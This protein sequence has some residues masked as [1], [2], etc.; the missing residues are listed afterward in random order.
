MMYNDTLD[1]IL[2]ILQ[3]LLWGC[4]IYII[5]GKNRLFGLFCMV[6]YLYLLPT[7]ITY[8]FFHQ[9]SED[10]W[11]KDVWYEFYGFVSLSLL[12]L[13]LFFRLNKE[14]FRVYNV[15]YKKKS[16]TKWIGWS[17]IIIYSVVT[18]YYLYTNIALISYHSLVENGNEGFG[19]DSITVTDTL[20]KSIPAFVIL[21]LL[22]LN[23]KTIL[24]KVFILYNIIIFFTYAFITG[25]RSDMLSFFVAITLLWIYGRKLRLKQIIYLGTFA[26]LFLHIAGQMSDLR[27]IESGSSLAETLLKQD[28]MAPAYN[29]LGVQA[30]QIVTPMTVISSNIHKI[31][32]SMGG[33][34]LYMVIGPKIFSF[35]VSASASAGFHSFTEG[36]LFVGF[37]GFLYNGIVMGAL[38]TLWYRFMRTNDDNFNRFM[39]ALMGCL[40]F[41]IISRGQYVHYIRNI[42][43]NFLP[44]SFIYAQLNNV[45]IHYLG[46]F[47][48]RKRV[49]KDNNSLLAI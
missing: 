39:F 6:L 13:F 46:F 45:N 18:S 20:V 2:L 8:R 25:N 49:K 48:T 22:S 36:Y 10:Y 12:T 5:W 19:L 7:E 30:K 44:V 28:Y 29:I 1:A 37:C 26:I 16:N 15:V 33:E 21:P 11:G 14:K 17:I 3:A 23:N 35:D 42:Y 32:P 34:W 31:F 27:G 4:A 40:F 47:Q 38:I 41:A 43:M 24:T 9:F